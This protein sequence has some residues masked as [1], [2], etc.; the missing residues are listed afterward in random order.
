MC[1]KG[2]FLL[3]SI[4]VPVLHVGLS[5]RGCGWNLHDTKPH[6]GSN[7][8]VDISQVDQCVSF[9]ELMAIDLANRLEINRLST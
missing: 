6:K 7:A 9:L 2:S 4:G 8:V 1:A 3:D 5:W